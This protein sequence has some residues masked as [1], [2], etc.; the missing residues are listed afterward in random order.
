MLLWN[1]ESLTLHVCAWITCGRSWKMVCSN[2]HLSTKYSYKYAHCTYNTHARHAIDMKNANGITPRMGS[3]FPQMCALCIVQRWVTL[4]FSPENERAWIGA[5]A[6]SRSYIY[7]CALA[8]GADVQTCRVIHTTQHT[9]RT[10]SVVCTKRA[11]VLRIYGVR[12][13]IVDTTLHLHRIVP[14][15]WVS[16]Q[17]CS[18]SDA[19]SSVHSQHGQWLAIS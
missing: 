14:H 6:N 9:H 16:V 12:S 11:T 7:I 4:K 2:V 18:F 19:N 15:I 10:I 5:L 13:Q 17:F 8:P 3:V 1:S